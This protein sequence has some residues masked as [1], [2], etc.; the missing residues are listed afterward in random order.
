MGDGA[1]TICE[2][3]GQDYPQLSDAMNERE[4]IGMERYGAPL[5]PQSDRRNF[6]HEAE[7][8]LLDACVYIRA[9][10]ERGQV[11]L[12]SVETHILAAID[13]LRLSRALEGA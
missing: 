13:A 11:V 9:L 12:P 6:Y 5:D 3:L 2:S 10:R 1:Q 7:E 4:R 8:E